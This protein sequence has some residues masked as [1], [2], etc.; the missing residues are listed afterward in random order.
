MQTIFQK[1]NKDNFKSLQRILN[2][3][4][5]DR[6]LNPLSFEVTTDR[7]DPLIFKDI[8]EKAEEI[9]EIC[10][11]LNISA[12][13][14]K[15]SR[16]DDFSSHDMISQF[17]EFENNGQIGSYCIHEEELHYIKEI[18]NGIAKI[19]NMDEK[20]DMIAE[21]Y[22]RPASWEEVFMLRDEGVKLK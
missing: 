22:I 10:E 2:G 16:N 9:N 19:V 21:N 4:S 1:I 17:V 12:C 5:Y 11:L 14:L 18:K 13:D 6:K 7:D 15:A 8:V 3:R 20:E